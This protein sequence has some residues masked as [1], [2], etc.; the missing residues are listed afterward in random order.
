[1]YLNYN[2]GINIIDSTATDITTVTFNRN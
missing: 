2:N 1:M